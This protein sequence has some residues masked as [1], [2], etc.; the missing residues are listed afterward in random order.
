MLHEI[1]NVCVCCKIDFYKCLQESMYERSYKLLTE[2]T[3]RGQCKCICWAFS[4]YVT[5]ATVVTAKILKSTC[6]FFRLFAATT[7]SFCCR[8]YLTCSKQTVSKKKL[9][10]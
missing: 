6:S 1:I 8:V 5:T 10:I 3:V 2:C 7:L 4:L 9:K